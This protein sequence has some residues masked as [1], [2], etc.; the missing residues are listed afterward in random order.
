M[1]G[2]LFSFAFQE[3][4]PPHKE[5]LGRDPNWWIFRVFLYVHV[6][7]FDLNNS[8]ISEVKTLIQIL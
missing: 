5:F 8:Y 4:N 3:K 7:F 2:Y 6:L 1:W